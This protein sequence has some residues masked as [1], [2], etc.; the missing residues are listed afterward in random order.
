MGLTNLKRGSKHELIV[1]LMAH[2]FT[3]RRAKAFV[4]IVLHSIIGALQTGENVQIDGFGT[5]VIV[6]VGKKRA[7]RFGKVITMRRRRIKFK[8]DRPII[9]EL[10]KEARSESP[11][12]SSPDEL[13]AYISVLK[14]F[15]QKHLYAEDQKQFWKLRWNSRSYSSTYV[16]AQEENSSRYR[17]E[18]VEHAITTTRPKSFS[19]ESIDRSND[20]V[21][22]YAHWSAQLDVNRQLWIE[23]ERIVSRR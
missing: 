10:S 2:G 4:E 6:K 8:F 14:Q 3:Y 9:A 21:S 22:W 18:Q 12:I 17:I 15:L 23:A 5:W 1:A 7:W 13:R 20:L 19:P 11:D 16:I